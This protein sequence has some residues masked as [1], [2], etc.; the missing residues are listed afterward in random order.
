MPFKLVDRATGAAHVIPARPA[1]LTIGRAGA[2]EAHAIVKPMQE[3]SRHH[4]QLH[5][6]AGSVM[7]RVLSPNGVYVRG[8]AGRFAKD[9]ATGHEPFFPL[10]DGAEFS[11]LRPGRFAD[12][13]AFFVRSVAAEAAPPA[14]AWRPTGGASGGRVGL[15]MA[16]QTDSTRE[17][18]RPLG[19]TVGERRHATSHAA[20]KCASHISLRCVSSPR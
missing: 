1:E 7:L 4:A 8:E 9:P 14:E 6:S 13:V 18:A 12:D 3:V 11:L 2:D 5:E 15:S 16:A 10:R 17:R 19:A 20:V